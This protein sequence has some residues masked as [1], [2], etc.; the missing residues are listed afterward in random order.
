MFDL[1]T[2]NSG[3]SDNSEMNSYKKRDSMNP[4][5]NNL[6]D[7]PSV[8]KGM[9]HE[10]RTH[11]NAIVAFSFLLK[12][13]CTDTSESREY[14]SQILNSCEQ[15][16]GLFDSFLDTS[17]INADKPA[18]DPRICKP[19]NILDD[20]FN[21]LRDSI[22]KQSNNNV[23]L[24]KEACISDSSE[25]YIDKNKIFR[26]LR[27]LVQVS[28]K[29]TSSGYIKIGYQYNNEKITFYVIDSGQ[30]YFKCK[31]FLNTENI[32]ESLLI[33]N[34]ITSAINL[35]LA[36]KLI[37]I[38]GGSIRIES[39]GPSGTGVYFSIPVKRAANH[40]VAIKKYV[41]TMISI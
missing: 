22:R 19:D 21:E 13:K 25:V 29:T 10:M 27:S 37:Q 12:E 4:V 2:D 15:L 16:I 28:A 26:V 14:S 24:I 38:M 3:G 31:E 40:D 18:T 7:C 1:Q 39:N 20:L 5:K 9:S 34:D 35:T 33:H 23:E 41:N 6:T 36:R 11:M 17:I 8:L 32:S 30:G